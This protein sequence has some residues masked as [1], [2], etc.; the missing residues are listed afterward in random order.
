LLACARNQ[1]QTAFEFWQQTVIM[2]KPFCSK[3]CAPPHLP[4]KKKDLDPPFELIAEDPP[5]ISGRHKPSE[6]LAYSLLAFVFIATNCFAKNRR[7]CFANHKWA[8]Q[9]ASKHRAEC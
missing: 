1:N 8:K 9:T 5:L 3:M 7:G 4:E 2:G 6:F